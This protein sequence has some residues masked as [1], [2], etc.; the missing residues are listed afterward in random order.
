MITKEQIKKKIHVAI[1]ESELTQREIAER[2]GVHQG[3][4]SQYKKGYRMPSIEVFVKL[5][6]VLELDANEILCIFDEVNYVRKT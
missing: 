1:E 5:C 3:T 6:E 2:I 4:V